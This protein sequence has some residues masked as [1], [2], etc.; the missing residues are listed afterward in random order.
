MAAPAFFVTIMKILAAWYSGNLAVE[1][2]ADWKTIQMSKIILEGTP[3][4]TITGKPSLSKDTIDEKDPAPVW[5][6][7]QLRKTV[8]K[9]SGLVENL[10]QRQ[11]WNHWLT[12]TL[13]KT[14]NIVRL[15]PGEYQFVY[16]SYVNYEEAGAIRKRLFHSPTIFW[17][18]V[19]PAPGVITIEAE[20]VTTLLQRQAVRN[21]EV[22]RFRW[23]TLLCI[24]WTGHWDPS[25]Q[26]IHWTDS[27]LVTHRRHWRWRD[28]WKPMSQ[29]D[30]KTQDSGITTNETNRPE[31]SEELRQIPWEVLKVEDGMIVFRRGDIGVLVYDSKFSN[32]G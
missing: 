15:E 1:W 31:R 8:H 10:Q 9:G 32:K 3:T 13:T 20:D 25:T 18:Y 6:P 21:E 2:Y 26:C 19:Q 23:R 24:Y 22:V 27:T 14:E 5:K 29:D 11:L 7:S 30:A 17:G 4:N 12:A 16:R 28:F